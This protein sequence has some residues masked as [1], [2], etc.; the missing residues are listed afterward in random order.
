[1]PLWSYTPSLLCLQIHLSTGGKQLLCILCK[2][3]H[4][5]PALPRE[6]SAFPGPL[7]PGVTHKNDVIKFCER[8]ITASRGRADIADRESYILLWEMLILMLRQKGQVDSIPSSCF[9]LLTFILAG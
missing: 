1:M 9:K 8:K 6:L 7:K 3:L 5:F 2:Y 4:T